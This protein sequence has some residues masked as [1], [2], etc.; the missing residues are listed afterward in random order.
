MSHFSTLVIIPRD[1]SAEAAEKLVSERLA[2]FDENL[3]HPEHDVP[4]YCRG[5]AAQAAATAA[6][7]A[8]HG[9]FEAIRAAYWAKLEAER[10]DES[11]KAHIAPYV[12]TEEAALS[13]RDDKDAPD[14]T[15]DECGGSGT[16]K[17]TR[18]P[19]SKWDW[20]RVGGRWDGAIFGKD[21]AK[22]R[23]TRDGFNFDDVHQDVTRNR[24]RVGDFLATCEGG[25]AWFPFAIVTPD[26]KW[27]E[28]GSMGWWGMV[29]DEKDDW[30]A[31]AAAILRAHESLDGVLCDL[32]I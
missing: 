13:T 4:C 1:I 25:D 6:A 15:C 30:P 16:R 27:N 19:D 18:N 12:A 24:R 21:E 3:E 10:T 7:V 9:P 5:T 11:W 29:A 28:K 8:A 23:E 22:R 32:H 17:T 26:G 14:P 2:P 31:Q 20:W